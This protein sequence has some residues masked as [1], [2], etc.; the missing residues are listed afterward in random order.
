MAA[1]LALP[2][3]SPAK[4]PLALGRQ[5]TSIG[6][7]T[8]HTQGQLGGPDLAAGRQFGYRSV[9]ADTTYLATLEITFEVLEEG[10]INVPAGT[11]YAFGIDTLP[12]QSRV[13][14]ASAPLARSSVATKTPGPGHPNRIE[15]T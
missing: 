1:L 10:L 2:A 15:S 13:S 9:A 14:A 8:R 5:S 4:S 3:L 7:A 11:F 6:I 12:A